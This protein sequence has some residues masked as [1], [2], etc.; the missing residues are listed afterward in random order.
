MGLSWSLRTDLQ[1]VFDFVNVFNNYRIRSGE[2]TFYEVDGQ[3][4]LGTLNDTDIYINKEDN[5]LSH[6]HYGVHVGV[7]YVFGRKVSDY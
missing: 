6:S 5:R 3:D 2:V 7:R 4:R 1:L